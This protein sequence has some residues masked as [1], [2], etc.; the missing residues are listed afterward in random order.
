[1]SSHRLDRAL[2]L[3]ST[4][5]QAAQ[6]ANAPTSKIKTNRAETCA[7][8]YFGFGSQVVTCHHGL[9]GQ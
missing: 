4:A 6:P 9:G 3:G 5:A 8:F 1:M 7:A 2:G